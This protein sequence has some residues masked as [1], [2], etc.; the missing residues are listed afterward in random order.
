MHKKP[1]GKWHIKGHN[2]CGEV[3]GVEPTNP[4]K[5]PVEQAHRTMSF[6]ITCKSGGHAA[7]V[8]FIVVGEGYPIAKK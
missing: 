5:R 6:P 3:Y 2:H 1:F 7:V 8:P 4:V